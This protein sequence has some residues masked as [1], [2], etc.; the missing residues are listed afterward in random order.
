M[1]RILNILPSVTFYSCT[2]LLG[3][4]CLHWPCAGDLAVT[5]GSHQQYYQCALLVLQLALALSDLVWVG[6]GPSVL[7]WFAQS[8]LTRT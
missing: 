8:P 3:T 2:T 6:V 7:L 4:L 5:I 1:V